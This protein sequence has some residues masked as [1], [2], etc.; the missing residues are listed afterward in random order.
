MA[1]KTVIEQLIIEI[2]GDSKKFNATVKDLKRKNKDLEGSYKKLNTVAKGTFAAIGTAAVLLGTVATKAFAQF[3]TGVTNVAKTTNLAG[4]E[5]ED[6]KDEIIKMSE[7]IPVSTQKLL[8]IAT[9]AGQLGIKGSKDLSKFTEVI[10]KL[11]ATTDLEGEQAA[12]AIARI[13]NLTNESIQSVDQLGSTLVDLGN[14]FAASESEILEVAKDVAKATVQFKLSSAEIL[15]IS[16]AMASLGIAAEAGG[17]VVGKAFQSIDQAIRQQTGPAFEKLMELTGLTGEVLTKTFATD[18][19][20]VFSLFIEG[21]GKAGEEGRNLSAEMEEVGLSGIRVNKILPTLAERSD[22]LADAMERAGEASKDASALNKEAAKAFTTTNSKLLIAQTKLNNALIAVGKDIGPEAAD[23]IDNLS[24]AVRSAGPFWAALGKGVSFFVKGLS[25]I[26]QFAGAAAD[27]IGKGF[28]SVKKF[29]E[30]NIKEAKAESEFLKKELDK[31]GVNSVKFLRLQK[32]A[33]KKARK[34]EEKDVKKHTAKIDGDESRRVAARLAQQESAND[35][36]NQEQEDS[37]NEAFNEIENFTTDV[38]EDLERKNQKKLEEEKN[39]LDN[40]IN[41]QEEARLIESMAESRAVEEEI[42]QIER[43]RKTIEQIKTDAFLREERQRAAVHNKF[44]RDEQ[45]FGTGMAELKR[46]QGSAEFQATKSAAGSLSVLINSNNNELKAIGKAATIIQ[47]GISTAEAALKTYAAVAWIPFVGPGLGFGLAATLIAFGA[48]QASNVAAM[49][50]GGVVPGSG[51][52]DIVPAML[53]PGELVVP[54]DITAEILKRQGARGMREGGV[55]GAKESKDLDATF[56]DIFNI[57]KNFRDIIR[58]KDPALAAGGFGAEL[59]SGMIDPITGPLNDAA[60]KLL[61][62]SLRTSFTGN[63]LLEVARLSGV[64]V[65]DIRELLGDNEITSVLEGII[66]EDTLDKII[67]T[68]LGGGPI[69]DVITDFIGGLFGFQKGGIVPGAGT[70]D[71]VPALL[72]PGELVLP[73]SF[74][75]S[76]SGSGGGNGVGRVEKVIMGVEV[77]IQGDWV[78]LISVKLREKEIQGT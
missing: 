61:E 4:K 19:S 73:K 71:I 23:A 18:A 43:S 12:L 32:K 49:K 20:K 44:L 14:N 36:R 57:P 31:R 70:G 53:E 72:E 10:A 39:F 60:D 17:T 51:S 35:A 55:V 30:A 58:G 41:L 24:D 1:T 11:G 76:I 68:A 50:T 64:D 56:W 9:A 34:E 13:L 75:S 27:L 25:G 26:A 69:G 77:G 40:L 67:D 37:D 7:R 3:E 5:L 38:L 54:K 29:R 8:E 2:A 16:A 48:E 33:R 6:F 74:V 47:I 78:D 45:E 62:L 46:I 22:I 63:L 59:F 65:K 21:L 66:G 28:N 42:R 52:G 15:G